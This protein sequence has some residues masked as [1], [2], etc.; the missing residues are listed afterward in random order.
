[1]NLRQITNVSNPNIRFAAVWSLI[2]GGALVVLRI[3]V[4]L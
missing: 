2:T 4:H 1:M 3:G